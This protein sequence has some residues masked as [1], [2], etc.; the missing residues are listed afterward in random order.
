MDVRRGVGR[1]DLHGG[2]RAGSGAVA[3]LTEAAAAE[4]N[5][6]LRGCP[7]A[8]REAALARGRKSPNSTRYGA[9]QVHCL[10][11]AAVMVTL[12]TKVP[13]Q[14]IS[15]MMTCPSPVPVCFAGGDH[16]KHCIQHSAYVWPKT[17]LALT[18]QGGRGNAPWE[19]GAG[20]SMGR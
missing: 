1:L 20:G 4:L 11:P 13:T 3:G 19:A 18:I 16:A 14:L 7:C 2:Q 6:S 8:R 10:H 9:H 17:S 5:C 15:A 12:A